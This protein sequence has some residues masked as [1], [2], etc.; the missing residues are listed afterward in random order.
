M[1]RSSRT[2]CNTATSV[3]SRVFQ[4]L[5]LR[6]LGFESRP[7]RLIASRVDSEVKQDVTTEILV[8]YQRLHLGLHDVKLF[9]RDGFSVEYFEVFVIPLQYIHEIPAAC[10]NRAS[11]LSKTC[12]LDCI[13]L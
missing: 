10:L 4:I 8:R 3:P 7:V 2:F 1:L 6:G 9:K 12:F 13:N 11:R 5:Y